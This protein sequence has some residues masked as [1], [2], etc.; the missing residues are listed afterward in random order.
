MLRRLRPSDESMFMKEE[1]RP[2][3][4]DVRH[5]ETQDQ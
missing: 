1:V 2:S 3:L 4:K 5:S